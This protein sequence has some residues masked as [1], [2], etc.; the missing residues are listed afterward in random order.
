[1]PFEVSFNGTA[2]I[3]AYLSSLDND[4]W[5]ITGGACAFP[6]DLNTILAW[7]LSTDFVH[8]SGDIW[9]FSQFLTITRSSLPSSLPSTLILLPSIA[10]LATLLHQTLRSAQ[11]T[12]LARETPA[13]F[14][15]ARR[16]RRKK[17]KKHIFQQQRQRQR[18]RRLQRRRR[19]RR[20]WPAGRQTRA[21]AR[22]RFPLPQPRW[23]KQSGIWVTR[24]TG[25]KRRINTELVWHPPPP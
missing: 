23:W 15:A 8:G 21:D 25:R 3:N 16:R 9:A 1:M 24:R 2:G 12:P 19:R 17:K 20:L 6:L 13:H 4:L 5:P 11:L 22:R 7:T 10:L 14:T 18:Q